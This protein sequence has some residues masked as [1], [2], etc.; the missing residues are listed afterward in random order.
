MRT[1]SINIDKTNF[2]IFKPNSNLNKIIDTKHLILKIGSN[3][4]TRISETKYLGVVID[5]NLTWSNHIST[6]IN[7]VSSMIGI[8]YR[9]RHLLPVSCIKT[10]FFTGLFSF[11]IWY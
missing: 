11:D 10:V 6:L 2:M 9:R 3:I 8:M 4:I 7:K 5:E 1:I